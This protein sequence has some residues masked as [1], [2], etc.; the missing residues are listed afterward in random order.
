VSSSAAPSAVGLDDADDRVEQN[1]DENREGIGDLPEG[2]GNQRRGDQDQD[3]EIAKLVEQHVEETVVSIRDQP[4]QA[5]GC[6]ALLGLQVAQSLLQIRLQ[7]VCG[8]RDREGVPVERCHDVACWR[9]IRI[10]APSGVGLQRAGS[11][12]LW[13]VL[14]TPDT[15]A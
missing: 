2:T 13:T 8:C 1:D 12:L 15:S 14:V 7:A 4:I 9:A 5:V 6:D 3:H 11:I 10:E